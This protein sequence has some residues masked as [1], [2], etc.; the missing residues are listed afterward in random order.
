MIAQKLAT[1][2]VALSPKEKNFAIKKKQAIRI[3]PITIK[4]N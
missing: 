4:A 1:K 3:K 2:Q